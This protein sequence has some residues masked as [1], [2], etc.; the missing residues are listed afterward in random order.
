MSKATSITEALQ[1]WQAKHDGADCSLATDVQL[2][3]QD[4]PI[5][6]MDNNLS[7]LANCEKL[8]LSTNM[9]ERIV[10][11]N[12]LKNLKILSLARNNIKSLKGLEV[13]GETLE[14]LW[15]SYNSIDKLVGI[16]ALGNLKIL[17]MSHNIVKDW[18]EFSRLATLPFLEDLAFLGNPLEENN[19]EATYRSEVAKRL[20]TL[21]KID[22]ETII[23]ESDGTEE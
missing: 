11:L 21:K 22:G 19:D 12:E 13:V 2:Q 18:S 4:P 9:I 3:L 16:Q 7:K 14:Q 15:I 6:K 8:S 10:G 20:K 1:R 17:Y 23:R 5:E